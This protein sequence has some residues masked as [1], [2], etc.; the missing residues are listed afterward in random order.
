VKSLRVTRLLVGFSGFTI[1]VAIGGIA[2]I[3]WPA[4]GWTRSRVTRKRHP[5]NWSVGCS[6]PAYLQGCHL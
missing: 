6:K 3:G 5:T 4:A 2:D 1:S